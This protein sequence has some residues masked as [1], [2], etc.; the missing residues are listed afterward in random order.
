MLI[1]HD[2]EKVLGSSMVAS[3]ISVSALRSVYRSVT[4]RASLWKSPARSNQ[5]WSF[6]SVTVT[7]SVSPSQCPL[8]QP[9]QLSTGASVGLSILMDRTAPANSYAIMIACEDWMI[10]NG[11]GMYVDRGTPPR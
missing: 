1:F 8:D 11:Y 7:T 3:Y 5:V 2:R 9:I 4:F 10:W 6:R